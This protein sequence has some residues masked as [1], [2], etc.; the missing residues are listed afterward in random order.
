MG[1][2]VLKRW[3]RADWLIVSRFKYDMKVLKG[4]LFPA[5]A[6]KRRKMSGSDE[7]GMDVDG[8]ASTAED[9]SASPVD[10]EEKPRGIVLEA[11]TEQFLLSPVTTDAK[12]SPPMPPP[13]LYTV[14]KIV[15]GV[16]SAETSSDANP[17]VPP[18]P[19]EPIEIKPPP[20]TWSTPPAE[21]DRTSSFKKS[22]SPLARAVSAESAKQS[23]GK[24]AA[25]AQ[26]L[27]KDRAQEHVQFFADAISIEGLD[28]G[29]GSDR[30]QVLR[31]RWA[32]PGE[33]VIS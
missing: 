4:L 33:F 8:D 31:W 16:A 10:A 9:A 5:P 20:P 3:P 6:R 1:A 32:L 7:N 11:M 26:V 29:S 12:D 28:T 14:L 24:A 17:V 15:E 19:A 2:V 21:I 22:S 27:A 30:I 18:K 13:R 25:A 23:R